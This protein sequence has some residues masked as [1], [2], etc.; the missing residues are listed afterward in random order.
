LLLA[1]P[2]SDVILHF[3]VYNLI[4]KLKSNR[5]RIDSFGV[6][7][8]EL[9]IGPTFLISAFF[10]FVLEKDSLYCRHFLSWENC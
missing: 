2:F 4:H 10:W 8:S 1:L 6:A 3:L 9:I 5:F 7:K